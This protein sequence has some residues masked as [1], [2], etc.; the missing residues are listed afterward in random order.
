MPKIEAILL[1]AIANMLVGALWYSEYLFGTMW[2]KLTRLRDRE[3]KV[4]QGSAYRASF[5]SAI[6][7][8]YVMAY[9]FQ[10][11]QVETVGQAASAGVWLWLGFVF[12]THLT[13]TF[14][15]RRS[16][17]LMLI[18]TGYFLIAMVV[19][20]AVFLLFPGK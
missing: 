15:S 7:M 12:T 13:T 11:T 17:L 2:R 5:I 4:A 9:L 14:F 16:L 18:D 1:A 20:G 6:L 19:M 3:I 10:F 8:A